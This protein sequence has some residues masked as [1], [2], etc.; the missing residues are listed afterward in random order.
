VLAALVMGVAPGVWFA[1]IDPA[2]RAVLSPL[3][4]AAAQVVGR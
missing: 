1:A 4:H 2:T 3:G